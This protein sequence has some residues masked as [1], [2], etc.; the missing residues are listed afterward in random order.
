MF[1]LAQNFTLRIILSFTVCASLLL[2][3]GVSLLSEASQGQSDGVR[4]ARP[5]HKRPEGIRPNL[6][7]VKNESN[8]EREAPPP[9][10]ST[11]VSKHR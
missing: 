7:E 2:V 10:P 3:P 1:T 4:N 9:I 8:V 11:P 6:E 5:R